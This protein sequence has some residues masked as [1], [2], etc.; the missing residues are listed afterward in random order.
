MKKIC[1][2]DAGHGGKDPGAV[3]HGLR[4]KDLTLDICRR[5][6]DYMKCNYPAQECRLSRMADQDL[7]LGARTRE[8]NDWDAAC[9]VS[10]HINAHGSSMAAGFESFRHSSVNAQSRAGQLQK[11]LHDNISPLWVMNKRPDRGMKQANFHVLRETRMPAVLLEL[12][13][14]SNPQDAA[15]L[16]DSAFL[17]L[18]AIAI[19]DA[20]AEFLE[21]KKAERSSISR[22]NQAVYRVIVEGEQVGAFRELDNVLQQVRQAVSSG[23]EIELKPVKGE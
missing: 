10:V 7:T 19:G 14:I 4:E 3:E 6:A 8:A 9:F 23:K 1:Y 12:G 2:L 20:V 21:I 5:V 16:K 17:D 11:R 22:P 13:F 18:H 15:L